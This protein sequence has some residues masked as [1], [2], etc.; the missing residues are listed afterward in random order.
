[1]LKKKQF[2]IPV[3]RGGGWILIYIIMKYSYTVEL[4]PSTFRITVSED[5]AERPTDTICRERSCPPEKL[6]ATR[7]FTGYSR[8]R[9]PF[10]EGWVDVFIILAVGGGGGGGSGHPVIE[11]GSVPYFETLP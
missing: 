5:R 7:R 6:I 8:E 11:Q 10:M 3:Q 4:F 2:E 9:I 1:M